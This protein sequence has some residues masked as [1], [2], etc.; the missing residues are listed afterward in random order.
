MN[1]R[2]WFVAAALTLTLI[3]IAVGMAALNDAKTRRE[4]RVRTEAARARRAVIKQRFVLYD[5][6]Q[7]VALRN[8]ELERFGERHDGGYLMCGNLL[9]GVQAAYSYGIS[10][11]DQW[12]CDIATRFNVTTHQYDCF[13]LTQPLCAAGKTVFHAECVAARTFTEEGRLFDSIANQM[14]KNGDASKQIVL[15]ID[16]EGAEWESL[17]A[18]PDEVLQ[19]IDQL[20]VEFHWKHDGHFK[21]YPADTYI[22]LVQRLK[23]FFEV[24]H[25]HFNNA[26]CADGLE[27]FSTW[28]FE[29]LFVNKRLAVVDPTRKA[30]GL[31]PLDAK[32]DPSLPDCQPRGR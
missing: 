2:F 31:H 3:V 11:Y 1:R 10:G 19:R 30:A 28:A 27:P 29:V 7:P 8:C 12:G 23:Q 4:R 18:A 22:A 24:A 32:N 25:L 13:N 15:K 17:L 21:W 14:T 20:T 5:M 9:A 16:V 6:L 26:A